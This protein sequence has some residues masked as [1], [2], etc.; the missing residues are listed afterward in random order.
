MEDHAVLCAAEQAELDGFFEDA[1]LLGLIRYP[2]T[3]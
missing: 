3:R 1:G 2:A